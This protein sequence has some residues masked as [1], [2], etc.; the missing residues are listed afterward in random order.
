MSEVKFKAY[1]FGGWEI[2]PKNCSVED[3]YYADVFDI[4]SRS[5]LEDFWEMAELMSEIDG[6]EDFISQTSL[7]VEP[8]RYMYFD[9]IDK[10]ISVD[11]LFAWRYRLDGFKIREKEGAAND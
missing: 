11:K 6:C 8:G 4:D 2:K 7:V 3:Y 5:G 10:Y 1:T 9:E